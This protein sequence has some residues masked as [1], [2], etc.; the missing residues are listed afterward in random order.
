VKKVFFIP[1]QIDDKV[2][3]VKEEIVAN[4]D[5]K[6]DAVKEEIVANVDAK[7]DVVK[8]EIDAVKQEVKAEQLEHVKSVADLKNIIETKYFFS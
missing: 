6:V 8:E 1:A 2:D 5:A 3:A 4:V 7:V